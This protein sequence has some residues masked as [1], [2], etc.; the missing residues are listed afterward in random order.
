MN[1][2]Q[3][4]KTIVL[5]GVFAIPFIPILV[6]SALFFPFITGKNF[7]FRFVVEIILSAWMLLAYLDPKYRPKWT[8]VLTAAGI[9]VAVLAVADLF[10]ENAYRSFWSNFE[11]MEGLVTHLHLFAYLLVAG[12]VLNSDMRVK[13]PEFAWG[14]WLATLLGVPFLLALLAPKFDPLQYPL[15]LVI[16]GGALFYLYSFV[17][18]TMVSRGD[19]WEW[20][21]ITTM[22]VSVYEGALGFMQLFGQADI[23]QSSSRL[24]ATFGNATYFAVYAMFQVFLAVFFYLREPKKSPFRIYFAG[25]IV[26]LN[27]TMIFFSQTRGAMLGLIFGAGLTLLLLAIFNR[28]YP[29]LRKYAGIGFI[30]VAL[31]A[32]SVWSMR[33]SAFVKGIPTLSRFA[34]I[35]LKDGNSRFMI[36]NMSWQGVKERPILGWGQDNFIYV[37]AKHY[38]PKMVNQEPWFDRSHNVFFDWLIAAGFLGLAAYLSFFGTAVYMVWRSKRLSL[39]ERS[40]LVGLLG[41]YFV[42][43]LFVFDNITSYL[44]FFSLLA[45]IHALESHKKLIPEESAIKDIPKKSRVAHGD[46]DEQLL[47]DDQQA[48]TSVLA[49]VGVGLVIVLYVVVL[50]PLQQ[51]IS[52]IHSLSQPVTPLGNGKFKFPIED[53]IAMGTF[54]RSEAREQLGQLSFQ[55]I[56]PRVDPALKN[57]LYTYTEAEFKDELKHDPTNLRYLFFLGTFYEKFGQIDKAIV[58][59]QKAVLLSPRRQMAHMELGVAYMSKGDYEN[60]AKSIKVAYELYPEYQEA[61]VLYAVSLVTTGK[62][63]LAEEILVPLKDTPFMYDQRLISAYQISGNT[64]KAK[65]LLDRKIANG[66]GSARDYLILASM[67]AQSG[68]TDAAISAA[69]KAKSLD[70]GVSAQADELISS[71]KA[72]KE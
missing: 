16:G 55:A 8:P 52:L 19:P 29:K 44:Q 20:F 2:R 17:V 34:N 42:Q 57:Q 50:K 37:F 59:L 56:D 61:R 53:T 3:I 69:E 72:G 38:D 68:D 51:N 46:D 23:H 47:G 64:P 48:F 30:T 41:G 33:D 5:T 27:V 15:W 22:G 36:W 9:F 28:E 12:T 60:A 40:L 24:D 4:L 11:R 45:F 67:N 70:A 21:F 18:R 6:P 14:E 31:L 32:G 7:M 25:V 13:K 54:G 58:E 1:I 71:L 66:T 65:E 43:N 63:A 35:T 49:V 10:G 39:I 26:V 62:S